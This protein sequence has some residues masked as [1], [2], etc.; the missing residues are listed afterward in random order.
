MD[1]NSCCF[2]GEGKGKGRGGYEGF[3][4]WDEGGGGVM[5]DHSLRQVIP[6]L[7]PSSKLQPRGPVGCS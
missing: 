6:Q 7:T 4:V 1:Y 5:L 2:V 3:G